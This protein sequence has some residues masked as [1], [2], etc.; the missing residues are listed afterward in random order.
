MKLIDTNEAHSAFRVLAKTK[1]SEAAVMELPAEGSTGGADNKHAGED[2]WLYVVS[3]T[4]MAIVAGKEQTLQ[5]GS[6]L[7]IEAGETHEI[8][9]TGANVLRTLNFYA[10]PAY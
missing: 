7:L 5:T 10:P 6:L 8:M 1:R 9:N 2:Q 3:G 4:G